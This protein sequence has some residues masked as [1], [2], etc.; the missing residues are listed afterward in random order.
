MLRLSWRLLH[1]EEQE[2]KGWRSIVSIFTFSSYDS[3]AENARGEKV[4]DRSERAARFAPASYTQLS[5]INKYKSPNERT[6]SRR[7]VLQILMDLLAGDLHTQRRG[8]GTGYP[9]IW[10]MIVA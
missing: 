4:E 1:T 2:N 8:G 9:K 6:T 5:K 7:A 3:R 10:G